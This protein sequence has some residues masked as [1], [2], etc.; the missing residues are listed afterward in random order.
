MNSSPI[1][2]LRIGHGPTIVFLHGFMGASNDWLHIADALKDTFEC[3]LLDLPGHGKTPAPCNETTANIAWMAEQVRAFMTTQNIGRCHLVGYSMGAR[4]ALPLALNHPNLLQSMTIESNE[5]GLQ[6]E[7]VRA[8][9]VHL[10]TQRAQSI[11]E[12]GLD[13]FLDKWYAAPLFESLTKH[14]QFPKTLAKRRLNAPETVAKIIQ[15]VSA[16]QQT[17]LWPRV[18]EL[19]LPSLW[20]TG[21]LDTKYTPIVTRAAALAPRSTLKIIADAGHNAHLEQPDTYA[22][23]LKKF[24][25]TC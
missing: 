19:S 25:L 3:V 12:H 16:G 2:Y 23:T 15:D 8:D 14:P 20:I 6:D 7:K 17:N 22:Q 18:C 9:R 24:L 11:R 13:A 4:I 5:P 1:H 10:D 21:E